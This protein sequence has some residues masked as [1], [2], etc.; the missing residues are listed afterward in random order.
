M[1]HLMLM[2]KISADF[3]IGALE[4]NKLGTYMS[5]TLCCDV[6]EGVQGLLGRS[7]SILPFGCLI[8]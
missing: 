6:Y 3:I 8:F 5:M 2:P 4:D 7:I 1:T